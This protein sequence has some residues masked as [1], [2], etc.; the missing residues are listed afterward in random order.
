MFIN[1]IISSNKAGLT[2]RVYPGFE[3]AAVLGITPSC[4]PAVKITQPAIVVV[5]RI[6][7]FKVSLTVQQIYSYL[8]RSGSQYLV[9]GNCCNYQDQADGEH[10]F[11][12]HPILPPYPKHPLKLL[13]LFLVIL[14]IL[15]NLLPFLVGEKKQPQHKLRLLSTILKKP[16]VNKSLLTKSLPAFRKQMANS[17][18]YNIVSIITQLKLFLCRNLLPYYP[19]PIQVNNLLLMAGLANPVIVQSEHFLTRYRFTCVRQIYIK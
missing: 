16:T 13:L 5:W 19:D 4:I 18:T 17:Y 8:C 15:F 1:P 9:S 3:G 2:G 6:E 10:Y 14:R 7:V 12:P 11:L